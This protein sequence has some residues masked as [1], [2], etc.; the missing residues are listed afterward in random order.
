MHVQ[1]P[2][3][4]DPV[5]PMRPLALLSHLSSRNVMAEWAW[6]ARVGLPGLQQKAALYA[7]PA[8]PAGQ[9]NEVCGLSRVRVSCVTALRKQAPI[10]QQRVKAC[11][12]VNEGDGF[13]KLSSSSAALAELHRRCAP[14]PLLLSEV[15]PGRRH[16]L[17]RLACS[18][19]VRP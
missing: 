19:G 13:K 18:H 10:V 15:V 1:L 11:S 3:P 2:C 16:G 17:L 8:G 6:A 14:A 5:Q 7:A 9:G 12:L 4:Q